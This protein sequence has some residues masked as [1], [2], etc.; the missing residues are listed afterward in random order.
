MPWAV[1]QALVDFPAMVVTEHLS[2]ITSLVGLLAGAL[3]IVRDRQKETW[4]P[5]ATTRLTAN[6]I[7]WARAACIWIKAGALI[8]PAYII[9][10]YQAEASLT[11]NTPA[12]GV[13]LGWTAGEIAL[14]LTAFIACGMVISIACRRVHS[15]LLIAGGFVLA[16]GTAVFGAAQIPNCNQD[17]NDPHW[18]AHMFYWPATDGGVYSIPE[19]YRWRLLADVIWGVAVPISCWLILRRAFPASVRDSP[20]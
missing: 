11:P 1:R 15:A 7:I 12:V 17:Y 18:F 5:L 10:F 2:A 3:S 4:Q 6:E 13:M 14:R 8:V 16:Y 20:S 9:V 19:H